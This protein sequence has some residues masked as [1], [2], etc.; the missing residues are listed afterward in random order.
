IRLID[1]ILPSEAHKTC[2]IFTII[3]FL[4]VKLFELE[5]FW[6]VPNEDHFFSVYHGRF[7]EESCGVLNQIVM[8]LSF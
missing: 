7:G 3:N 4:L 8:D 2:H 1:K 5:I 6:P